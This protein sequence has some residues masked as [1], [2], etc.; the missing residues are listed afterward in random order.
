MQLAKCSF[1]KEPVLV[2]IWLIFAGFI[3][4]RLLFALGSLVLAPHTAW[5]RNN[6][7]R[8]QQP[9]AST[10][11][12]TAAP[13]PAQSRSRPRTP[14]QPAAGCGRVWVL[15]IVW[16]D[17]HCG[18]AD[19]REWSWCC[20]VARCDLLIISHS[21]TS[22]DHPHPPLPSVQVGHHN[23]HTHAYSMEIPS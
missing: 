20:C 9:A 8:P 16:G 12:S 15:R 5:A 14:C 19:W 4:R 10:S 6:A 23:R 18:T 2:S 21:P 13:S 11:T 7:P 3:S 22:C 17:H 1:E